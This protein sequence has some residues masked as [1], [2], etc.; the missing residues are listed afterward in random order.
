[1]EIPLFKGVMRIEEVLDWLTD[2]ERFFEV[3]EIPKNKKVRLVSVRLQAAASVW[4][5][6]T[7][8]SRARQQKRPIKSW[9]KMKKLIRKRFLPKD[10]Q[11]V[12]FTQ[13]QNC[14]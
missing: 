4:W 1:M 14:R 12:L 9:P 5:E 3:M 6:Q 8:N 2:V 11:R 13:Y 7:T 10:Y